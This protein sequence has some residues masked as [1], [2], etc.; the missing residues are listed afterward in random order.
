MVKGLVNRAFI[1]V[2]VISATTA[3]LTLALHFGVTKLGFSLKKLMPDIAR[4]NSIGKMKNMARE[5]PLAALQ[6]ASMLILFSA[7]IYSIARRNAQL[8]FALPFT[9][10][11]TG[12]ITVGGIHQGRSLE[13]CGPVSFVRFRRP[14]ASKASL[15]E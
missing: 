5:G 6:A 9:G 3:T 2:A 10:L 8:F 7:A 11:E 12:L 15:H 13:G 4:F 1:P 14:V